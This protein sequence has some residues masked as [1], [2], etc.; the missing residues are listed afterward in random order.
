VFRV[1]LIIFDSSLHLLLGTYPQ[2]YK[3]E[4]ELIDNLIQ[5]ALE[6]VGI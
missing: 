6:G 3:S 2:K 1:R 4:T 5:Q